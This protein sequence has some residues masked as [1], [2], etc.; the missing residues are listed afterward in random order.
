MAKDIWFTSDTHYGHKN[1]CKFMRDDGTPLRPW[2][3]VEEMNEAL[4]DNF[5]SVVKS[6]DKVYHLG[7]LHMEY[8]FTPNIQNIMR[9]LNGHKRLVMGNHDMCDT[10]EYFVYFE[11]LYGV[12]VFH[13]EGIVLSHIPLR[14]ENLRNGW[15]NLHGHT[16]AHIIKEKEGWNTPHP[17]Y[18]N[19]CVENTNFIPIHWDEVIKS[20]P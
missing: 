12:R 19:M 20:L 9:R 1:I 6:Q 11:K 2:D 18:R 13:K 15:I 14:E 17:R 7:D 8:S 16:H 4:I 5:N 10:K 3:D